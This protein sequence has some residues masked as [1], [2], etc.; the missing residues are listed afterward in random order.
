[1]DNSQLYKSLCGFREKTYRIFFIKKG[2]QD[3]T[4]GDVDAYDEHYLEIISKLKKSNLA[5]FSDAAGISRPAGT[6]VIKKFIEKGYVTKTLNKRD[7][8]EY[9]IELSDCA[10]AY[11]KESQELF[12][13]ILDEKFSVLSEEEISNLSRTL[14]K[15][16]DENDWSVRSKG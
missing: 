5:V 6:K 7:N 11:M 9:L 16:I 14:Q 3:F 12:S 2:L 4:I 13:K 15:L 8:R 1:M 10:K